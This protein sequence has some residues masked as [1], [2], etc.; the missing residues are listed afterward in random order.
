MKYHSIPSSVSRSVR[1]HLTFQGTEYEIDADTGA[2]R[3]PLRS[4]KHQGTYTLVDAEDL[5]RLARHPWCTTQHSGRLYARSSRPIGKRCILLHR[6]LTDAPDGMHVDHINGDSLDNRRANLRICTQKENM[7]NRRRV[8]GSR[9]PFIGVHLVKGRYE[10]RLKVDYTN[11]YLGRFDTPEEAA[12][13]R[14]EAARK[15]H[16]E[17]A[18]LNF[19]EE[20]GDS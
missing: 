11:L 7:R 8:K 18:Y 12:R 9:S 19:P 4:R 2:V 14:D 1:T 20:G 16:G 10:S 15:Y 17:F 13:V 6:F 5:P 3:Y